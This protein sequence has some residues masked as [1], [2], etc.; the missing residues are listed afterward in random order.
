MFILKSPVHDRKPERKENHVT[1][2]RQRTKASKKQSFQ[3]LTIITKRSILDV[4]AAIDPPLKNCGVFMSSHSGNENMPL[5][6]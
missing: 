6:E 4:A 5:V 3:P 2:P 1:R